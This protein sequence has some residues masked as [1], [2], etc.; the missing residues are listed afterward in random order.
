MVPAI[1]TLCAGLALGAA[2]LAGVARQEIQAGGV[3]KADEVQSAPVV[4][5]APALPDA[6]GWQALVERDARASF[7]L[8]SAALARAALADATASDRRRATALLALGCSGESSERVRLSRAARTG[9]PPE[10]LGATLGLSGLG[11]GADAVLAELAHDEE[12]ARAQCAVLALAL[13]RRASAL[14]TVE[15]FALSPDGPL[16][17]T[18]L[19]AL[20]LARDPKTSQPS[21]V[22]LLWFQLRF[23]AAKSFGLIDGRTWTALMLDT[24]AA[25]ADFVRDLVL[26]AA[27]DL[28]LTTIKDHLLGELIVGRGEYRLRAAVR[29]MPREVSELVAA[30][31]WRPAD[32]AEWT[33]LLDEIA[34]ERLEP[35]C[36]EV[37]ASAREVPE[38]RYHAL[39]LAARGARADLT[40]LRDLEFW[41]L[42]PA[43]RLWVCDALA[44]SGD[45]QWQK[46]LTRMRADADPDVK[47]AALVGL[48]RLGQERAQREIKSTLRTSD[49]AEHDAVVRALCRV[50]TDESVALLLEDRLLEATGAE[51]LAIARALCAAGRNQARS[52]VRSAL[53]SEPAPPAEEARALVESLRRHVTP[54]DLG[55]L[56]ALF[57]REDSRALNLEIAVALARLKDAAVV[58]LVRAGLWSS[59]WDRS[60]LAGGILVEISGMHALRD[61]IQRP[62][63]AAK[64]TDLRRV[65]YVI[66]AWGGIGEVEKLARLLQSQSAHPALQGAL[67]G[68]LSSRTR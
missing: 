3:V 42:A 28:E 30:E 29:G 27:P 53:A 5:T 8:R 41:R 38:V 32:A 25:D 14:A 50:A 24:L 21:S 37:L 13:S 43:E 56:T 1:R 40:E 7:P 45:V 49:D 67:L 51:R 52:V 68:A 62:P 58:P 36:A 10:R 60:C 66:G 44:A 54:E 48:G 33:V 20:E 4:E 39:A 26:G 46:V 9:A 17:E 22:G 47:A 59:E 6:A 19:R 57:L 15:A 11:T 63:A 18:A 55:V 2:V 23:E 31:L 12:R 35:L 34:A 61:E 16:A 64:S 65:G